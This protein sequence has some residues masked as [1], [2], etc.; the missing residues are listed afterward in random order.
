[1]NIQE[2]KRELHLAGVPHQT[3]E[4]FVQNF[5]KCP[6]VWKA[7][8]RFALEAAR[9]GKRI[10]AKAIMERVRWESEIESDREFKCGNSWIA[11]YARMFEIKHPQFRD[12]FDKREIKGVTQ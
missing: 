4:G 3:I 1:M 10:G 6:D 8:E 7:F 9:K 11:Y 2:A 5:M 12:F